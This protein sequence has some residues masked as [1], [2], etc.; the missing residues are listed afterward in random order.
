[1]VLRVNFRENAHFKCQGMFIT[2]QVFPTVIRQQNTMCSEKAQGDKDIHCIPSLASGGFYFY[3][4]CMYGFGCAR[5][6]LAA[7]KTFDLPCS[8][9]GLY[10]QHVGSS[11]PTGKQSLAPCIGSVVCQPQDRQGS[12]RKTF[13]MSD[14][15]TTL[16]LCFPCS[17]QH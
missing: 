13:F 10:L 12:P 15:P 1:M 17:S 11:S 4:V 9:W 7:F 6:L 8:M 14:S 16:I 3:F 2:F 5:S